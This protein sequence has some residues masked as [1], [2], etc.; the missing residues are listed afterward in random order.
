MR[1]CYD[2]SSP[3][4]RCGTRKQHYGEPICQS[5][6]IAHVDPA[7]SAAFLAVVQPAEVEA[8]LALSAEFEREQ[9]QVARQWQLRR[10]RARYDA[11]RARR[12]YDQCEPENRLV[13]RELE[14]RW[15]EKLRAVAE[16]ED[17]YRREQSRGLSP[18]TEEEKTLLRSLVGDVA[19]LWAATETTA[20][21]RKRLVRCLIR[22]V[23]VDR[24]AGANGRG[25]T[26]TVRIGWKSGAWT[27]LRVR[28]PS[29]SDHARTPAPVLGRIR[30]LAERLPDDR[31]AEVL[32]AEGATTRQGL[33][34][35]YLRVQRIRTRH[36]IATAC[37]ITPRGTQP[38][39]D[40]LVSLRAAAA[41]LG[42]SPSTLRHW[43]RWGFLHADQK[44]ADTPVWVRLTP[45]DITRL[46]GTA[47]AQGGGRWR[48]REAQEALGLSKAQVWEKARRG[49]LIAYRARV[50]DHWEWRL[51][52]AEDADRAIAQPVDDR[53]T[54][55]SNEPT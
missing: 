4:Y 6:S 34:W 50:A 43:Q 42:V 40:G 24:G 11:E 51:S 32:N 9:A 3:S 53:R 27:E 39:G 25:G 12:Q 33:P 19:T 23:V 26:T 36:R 46:D 35:T 5:L 22:E 13:A 29:S 49:E 1:P 52:P 21:E 8:L 2:G 55:A 30:A 17:E 48:L 16:V 54:V 44:G 10:E 37:P 47:A 14:T 20:A 38:R 31:I 41:A 28:R 18:L 15:N 45:D 7:V